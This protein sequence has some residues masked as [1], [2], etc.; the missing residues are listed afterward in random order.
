MKMNFPGKSFLS[1][2]YQY[3]LTQYG[4]LKLKQYLKKNDAIK[5]IIGAEKTSQPDWISTE[6]S[7]FDLTKTSDWE[8][9]F[10]VNS[11]TVLFAEHVWEHLTPDD[12]I[13]SLKNCYEYL[14]PNGF[15][16]IAV[17]DGFH[18]DPNYINLVKIN[19]TGWGAD[20]HKVLYDYKTLS[21]LLMQIGFKVELLE[22]FDENGQFQFKNWDDSGGRVRRSSRYDERNFDGQLNYTSLIVDGIKT[23]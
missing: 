16:R 11:I 4:I 3:F 2:T 13:V 18:P 19:G 12:A 15:I 14:K 7:F 10:K 9:Y 8:R 21:H 6:Q 23:K 5:I 22:Y 17:P 1:T 20:D